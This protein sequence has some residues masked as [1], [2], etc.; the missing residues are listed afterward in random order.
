MAQD[1]LDLPLFGVRSLGREH[2]AIEFG[3]EVRHVSI[4]TGHVPGVSQ[5]RPGSIASGQWR[6]RTS[7]RAKNKVVHRVDV[8]EELAA[9]DIP[10]AARLPG[11]IERA[12]QI[13]GPDV[14]VVIVG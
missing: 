7:L 12:R 5:R 4:E 9:R 1:V 11:G 10:D 8:F 3:H 6:S 14:K 2:V 13:V